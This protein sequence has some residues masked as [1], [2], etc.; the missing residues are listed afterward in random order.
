MNSGKN[1]DALKQIHITKCEVLVVLKHIKLYKSLDPNQVYPSTL[2]EAGKKLLKAGQ[3]FV[4]LLT[5]GEVLEA[6]LEIHAFIYGLQGLH[7]ELQEVFS[8]LLTST[9][10]KLLERILRDRKYLH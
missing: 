5:P 2:W 4:S 8:H 10:G 3:R 1:S 7:W 6:H 9:V